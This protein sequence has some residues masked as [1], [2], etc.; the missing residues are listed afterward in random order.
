MFRCT[1]P[2]G[3]AM[4]G[5]LALIGLFLS[6]A[7]APANQTPGPAL[8]E[9]NLGQPGAPPKNP[10]AGPKTTK[11]GPDH[12]GPSLAGSDCHAGDAPTDSGPGC[13]AAAGASAL[14]AID[15][16]LPGHSGARRFDDSQRHRL[17]GRRRFHSAGR[18]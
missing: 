9:T 15:V 3:R 7:S 2:S 18:R 17:A 1:A 13:R 8:P 4:A 6:A 12:T 5:L 14:S 11:N 16:A 10:V